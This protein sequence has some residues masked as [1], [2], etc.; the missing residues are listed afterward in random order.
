MTKCEIKHRKTSS[1]FPEKH[2]IISSVPFL[3][4]AFDGL[5][6]NMYDSTSADGNRLLHPNI[7]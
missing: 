4:T 6:F 5:M 1:S 3:V 7:N 2:S